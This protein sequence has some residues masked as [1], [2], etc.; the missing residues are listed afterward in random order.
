MSKSSHKSSASGWVP[1]GEMER[2][3][4]LQI[5]QLFHMKNTASGNYTVQSSVTLSKHFATNLRNCSNRFL[6]GIRQDD[7][8]FRTAAG[9]SQARFGITR[10]ALLVYFLVLGIYSSLTNKTIMRVLK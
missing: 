4:E 5:F 9:F 10:T 8:L 7:L 2:Q 6:T 3:G 1:A